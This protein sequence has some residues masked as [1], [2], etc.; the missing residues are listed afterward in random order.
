MERFLNTL[1]NK[2]MTDCTEPNPENNCNFN[3]LEKFIAELQTSHDEFDKFQKLLMD[4]SSAVPVDDQ[5]DSQSS[6]SDF[7]I[8][9]VRKSWLMNESRH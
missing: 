2:K 4:E 1:D 5:I 3:L 8:K 6:D 9:K 7:L